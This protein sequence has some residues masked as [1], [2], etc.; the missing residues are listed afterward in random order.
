M[1]AP[2]DH[3]G[4]SRG[5]SNLDSEAPIE[6]NIDKRVLMVKDGRK[7]SDPCGRFAQVLIDC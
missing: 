5:D 2:G 6:L 1:D 3:I 7:Y 4:W